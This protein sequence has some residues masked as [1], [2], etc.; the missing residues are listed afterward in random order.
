M[1]FTLGWLKD[2]LDTTSSIQEI[3][4]T[5]TS[6]GLEVEHVEDNSA[7]L[8]PFVV[9]R[10]LETAPH[11]QADKLQICTVDTGKE[12]LQIVCGAS[13][14]RAGINVV[15]AQVGVE[16]PEGNFK[17]KKSLI[18]GVESNGM[19]C[20]EEE[21]GLTKNS[22]GILEL[23]ADCPLGE[24]IVS[25]MGMDD[26]VIDIA[27]TPNRADCL[28][29]RGIARDLAAAGLGKLKPLTYAPLKSESKSAMTVH[30]TNS[31]ACPLYIGCEIKGVTNGESPE[32]M[33][34][35]LKAIGLRPI[36]ALVD[37]TNYL[38]VDLARPLHVYDRGKLKGSI[39]VRSAQNGEKF[40]A[41]NDKEY[42]LEEG[43]T[44]IADDSG[45]IGLGGIIGGAS[46]G[47]DA[48]TTDVFLEVALFDPV[49]IA[50]TGRKLAIDSDAR[51][52][53][54][55][56]LDAAFT[57][58]GAEIATRMITELCGGAAHTLTV[59]GEVPAQECIIRFTMDKVRSLGGA[60]VEAKRIHQILTELG[61]ECSP[62]NGNSMDVRVPAWRNDIQGEADLVEE[63][64][65]I[66]SYDN[67]IATAL[68]KAAGVNKPAL[69]PMQKRVRMVR[70]LLASRGML[71]CCTWSFLSENHAA[72]FGWKNDELKLLN[73]ISADLDTLRPS[74]LPNLIE[75]AKRNA[76]RGYS[77]LALFEV[78]K[79]F[80]SLAFEGE[81][82]VAAGIR[83]G[84]YAP[85]SIYKTQRVVDV[86]DAKEDALA[87]LQ[88][89]GINSSKI[90][91]TTGAPSW[92]H[93]GR[94]GVLTLGGKVVLGYFGELHPGTGSAMDIKF[95]VVGFEL[96][97]T[98]I[99]D[100]RNKQGKAK[101]P[102]IISDYQSVSRDFAFVVDENVR[103]SDISK[104]IEG[105]EKSLIDSV[106]IF[107]VYSGKGIEEGKKSVAVSVRLQPK[108][109]TFTDAEI[110]AVSTKIIEAAASLGATLRA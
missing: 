102:L 42:I 15:L 64:L 41:L 83:T 8:R 30:I 58:K 52:R 105:A 96:M 104:T 46:T 79:Q 78:G 70:R 35:R 19:L 10:I 86:F 18:R 100:T 65:R 53:S 40:K 99:P 48:S 49:N 23:P 75:A 81:Q 43:M 45:V 14:A 77:H 80:V 107:D 26:P 3:V 88:A 36:S 9:A 33:Q 109:T 72:L 34:R 20:S 103:A 28:G 59:S 24:S 110:E 95:P 69:T 6:V 68:P 44:V 108:S 37:I 7:M 11:P 2:H 22:E 74:L 101:P 94:S 55:R 57:A 92:Y 90:H 93:P 17:I 97:L 62:A 63:V 47:C 4:R 66:H 16:I 50:E 31:L 91:V 54:E 67:I 1:K 5:L 12:I 27:V 106:N 76:S 84:E 61:C 39:E 89:L 38:T 51:H 73:P 71:E 56:G 85:R 87:V 32:W 21:L 13:N 60:I 82:R 29:V 25:V 98:A